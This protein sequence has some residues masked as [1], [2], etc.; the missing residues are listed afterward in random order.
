MAPMFAR[1]PAL[2]E[3]GVW[4]EETYYNMGRRTKKWLKRV[5]FHLVEVCVLNAFVLEDFVKPLQ[6]AR[7]GEPKQDILAFK[8]DLAHQLVNAWVHI[9]A[10][11]RVSQ[12]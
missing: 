11:P 8:L 6:H 1:L 3:L 5:F 12:E 2:N 4:I 9:K 10:A 7:R